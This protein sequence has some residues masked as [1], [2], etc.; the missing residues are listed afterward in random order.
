MTKEEATKHEKEVLKGN[1]SLEEVYDAATIER[2]N[3]RMAEEER[4][5]RF[6]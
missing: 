5:E 6:R 1:K 4:F 3:K 2:V